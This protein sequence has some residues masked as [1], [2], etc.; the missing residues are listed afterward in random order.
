VIPTEQA[1]PV[2]G[3][4]REFVAPAMRTA[5]GR[6][7][8][9]MRPV[10]E[11]HFGWA[12]ADGRA[13]GGGGGK[14]V[15]PALAILSAEA[16]GADAV[17]GIPGGVSV[18]LVHNFSLIHDDVIDGD[19]ER[20]HRPTVWATFGIGRAVIVGDALLVLAQQILLDPAGTLQLDRVADGDASRRAAARIADSTAAMIAGQALDVACAAAIGAEL[21]G[22]PSEHVAALD[23]FGY[24]LGLAF[25]AVDD[26][27]GIWG[28]PARTGKPAWSDL[29]SHKKTFPVAAALAA[30]GA[31]AAELAA[32]LATPSLSDVQVARMAALVEQAGGREAATEEATRRLG[33]ALVAIDS[34][35]FVAAAQA[36]LAEVAR[37]VIEREF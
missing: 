34:P 9:E 17:I 31:G 5:V 25:Q 10:A 12:D 28:D 35:F 18:E 33:A 6:L 8:A 27:L 26:L 23:R 36:E 32:L 3:R 7:S 1:P 15:R 24:E 14:G 21:A 11:Y 13:T 2:F 22:A 30:G 37:F 16:V 4:A 29:R 19:V 20:R